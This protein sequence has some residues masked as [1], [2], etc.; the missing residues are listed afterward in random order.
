MLLAGAAPRC[1]EHQQHPVDKAHCERAHTAPSNSHTLGCQT[2]IHVFAPWSTLCQQ[3]HQEYLQVA[4]H[5]KKQPHIGSREEPAAAK[6]DCM[7]R[8]G[9][10]GCFVGRK[11]AR[12]DEAVRSK[13][14]SSCVEA[15]KR[16]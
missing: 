4:W 5:F 11:E 16:F 6:A 7:D 14:F 10:A 15:M 3:L 9:G 12:L 1:Q 8:G 2:L 13:T